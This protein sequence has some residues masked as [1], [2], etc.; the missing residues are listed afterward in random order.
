MGAGRSGCIGAGCGHCGLGGTEGAL[1]GPFALHSAQ[2][3]IVDVSA[4]A[5]DCWAHIS[6]LCAHCGGSSR[7]EI[8]CLKGRAS[9]RASVFSSGCRDLSS[10]HSRDPA[11]VLGLMNMVIEDICVC[12]EATWRKLAQGAAGRGTKAGGPS[13][14]GRRE[15][16]ADELP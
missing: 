9:C 10:E 14:P 4:S 15:R 12:A 6:A 1:A 8:R 3:V 16:R 11:D 5:K 13:R 7:T 2:R